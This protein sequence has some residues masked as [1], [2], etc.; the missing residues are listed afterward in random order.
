MMKTIVLSVQVYSL[1][2]TV[3]DQQE[4]TCTH[5]DD[6]DQTR[7]TLCFLLIIEMLMTDGVQDELLE[8]VT[9]AKVSEPFEEY[10][11]PVKMKSIVY[12]FNHWIRKILIS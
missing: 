2:Y 5:F 11:K 1:R 10:V 6:E 8:T 3:A 12:I 7:V 9:E 4:G